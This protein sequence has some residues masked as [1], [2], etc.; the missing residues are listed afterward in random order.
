MIFYLWACELNPFSNQPFFKKKIQKKKQ[1][2]V[3]ERKSLCSLGDL[4]GR[5]N[6]GEPGRGI[7]VLEKTRAMRKVI[8]VFLQLRHDCPDVW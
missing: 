3:V 7:Y 4:G 1:F 6:L 5:G 8:H 2:H